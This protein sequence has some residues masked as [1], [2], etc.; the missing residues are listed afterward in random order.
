MGPE[1]GQTTRKTITCI[2]VGTEAAE[3]ILFVTASGPTTVTW[4][5]S[6]RIWQR[7][8]R[9][10]CNRCLI[11]GSTFESVLLAMR[12][13]QRRCALTLSDVTYLSY[14]PLSRPA[15]NTLPRSCFRLHLEEVRV[16]PSS[17]CV[18]NVKKARIHRL[19]SITK[20]DSSIH[21]G[22]ACHSRFKTRPQNA[23][24][25]SKD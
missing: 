5:R 9:Y 3:R 15:T 18:V 21:F 2:G 24:L 13:E 8:R 11:A 7:C 4:N 12:V 1:L 6:L 19:G 22:A 23:H 25:V 16:P 14:C 10:G 20:Q 17:P